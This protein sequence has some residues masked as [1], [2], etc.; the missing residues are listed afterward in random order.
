MDTLYFEWKYQI[1]YSIK[2][3]IVYTADRR[4]MVGV[5]DY[6]KQKDKRTSYGSGNAVC[7]HGNDAYKYG[8]NSYEGAGFSVG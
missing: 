3:K 6:S 4:I 1:W 2:V 7:Y 5:L 8:P